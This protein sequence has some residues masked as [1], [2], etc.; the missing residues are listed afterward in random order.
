MC[1]N[2]CPNC[3]NKISILSI[4]SNAM[5]SVTQE[6]IECEKCLEN[7]KPNFS[8]SI[9]IAMIPQLFII[10][11]MNMFNLSATEIIIYAIIHVLVSTTILVCFTSFNL[12]PNDVNKRT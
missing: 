7:L 10:P 12:L 4:L 2:K 3:N 9:A 6:A 5:F 11:V 8:K 1:Q